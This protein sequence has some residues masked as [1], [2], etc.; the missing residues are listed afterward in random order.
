MDP[1]L[2]PVPYIEARALIKTG[3]IVFIGGAKSLF[4]WLI[5]S[6]TRS[7][8]SHCG[9]ACWMYDFPDSTPTLFIVEAN[10]LGR[11]LV[12]LDSY[13]IKR[14]MTILESPVDWM[15]Y[16]STLLDRTGVEPYS[17]KDLIGIGLRELFSF[18]IRDFSGEVCS[19]MV[20]TVLNAD[21]LGIPET[22]SP[23]RLYTTLLGRG[24]QIRMATAPKK[25]TPTQVALK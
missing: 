10:A 9:I 2:A 15:R 24:F 1:V 12:S 8:F 4:S 17:F 11:R 20:A 18:N 14:P 25:L 5:T 3:D 6:V 19:E 23:G 7:S 16:R 13:G 21:N 22:I